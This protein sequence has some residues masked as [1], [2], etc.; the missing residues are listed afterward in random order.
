MGAA[1][2]ADD[3]CTISPSI[4]STVSQA[5]TTDSGHKLNASKLE[6]ISTQPFESETVQI[7]DIIV[8]TSKCLSVWW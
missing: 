1:I 3:L 8:D 4:E 6:I 5:N 7:N 2:H